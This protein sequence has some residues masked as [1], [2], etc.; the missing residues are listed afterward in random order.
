MFEVLILVTV[1]V[2]ILG[3]ELGR[4]IVIGPPATV[5]ERLRALKG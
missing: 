2:V 1:A 3:V 4:R 5:L